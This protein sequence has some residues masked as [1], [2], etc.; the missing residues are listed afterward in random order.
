MG[1]IDRYQVSK[2]SII[3]FMDLYFNQMLDTVRT[4]WRRY[5]EYFQVLAHFIQLG[6]NETKFIIQQRAIA[7]L[8][9]FCMNCSAPFYSTTK[10]KMGDRV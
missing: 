1:H 7:K 2:A 9:E 5:D 4:H 3:R 10:F 8:L 6:F